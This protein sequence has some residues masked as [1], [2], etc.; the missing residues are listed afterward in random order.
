MKLRMDINKNA[1]LFIYT[2]V[3][4]TMR[5]MKKVASWGLFHL[6]SLENTSIIYAYNLVLFCLFFFIFIK[7]VHFF[8]IFSQSRSPIVCSE[9]YR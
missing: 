3:A 5:I 8:I 7:L 4:T 6:A 2:I 9:N 1:H